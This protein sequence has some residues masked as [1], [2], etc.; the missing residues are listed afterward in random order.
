MPNNSI[1]K[2]RISQNTKLKI[3]II[4][5]IV[6]AII[7]YVFWDVLA[8]GPIT[9][10][11]SNKEAIILWIN[12]HG[13]LAPF[14]FILLDI[15]Q[16]VLA[17]IPGQVVGGVG[18][19]LFGWWGILW[20]VIGTGLGAVLVFWLSR[21]FGRPLVE[22]LIKKENL[23]KFDFV[24]GKNAP[25]ILFLFF[26]IPATPDDLICYIG[27]LTE[28]SIKKLTA[29]FIL[30]RL[31]STV[32]VNYIGSG[33]GEENLMPVLVVTLLTVIILALALW[34]KDQIINYLK[35]IA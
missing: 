13:I 11:L 9:T 16:A 19:F 26:L 29:L 24:M 12:Q 30:G 14:A 28:I 35:K 18:G 2:N 25:F 34:K 23:D 32:V 1:F 8:G 3:S 10:F 15:L 21:R 27:G 20:T 7:I 33:L 31:P 17:P 6:L 5:A 4:V 22:K